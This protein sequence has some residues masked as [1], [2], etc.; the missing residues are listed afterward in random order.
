MQ[1]GSIFS[2]REWTEVARGYRRAGWGGKAM[3][4]LYVTIAATIATAT[5]LAIIWIIVAAYTPRPEAAAPPAVVE[6]P[7][8]AAPANGRTYDYEIDNL[9]VTFG[10][11]NNLRVV[12]AQFSLVVQCPSEQCL[13]WMKMNRASLRDAVFEVAALQNVEDFKNTFGVEKLKTA[14]LTEFQSRFKHTPP[15]GLLIRDWFM[16]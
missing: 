15:S 6:V 16:R 14:L 3:I 2:D 9:N 7:T 13:Q 1:K 5:V 11:K 12:Y 8:H 10:A 4:W